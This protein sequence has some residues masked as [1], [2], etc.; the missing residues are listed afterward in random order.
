M[1][2]YI[3]LLDLINIAKFPAHTVTVANLKF[4]H[5]LDKNLA[6]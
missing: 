4:T 3:L 1:R 6:R 2:Y 5:E